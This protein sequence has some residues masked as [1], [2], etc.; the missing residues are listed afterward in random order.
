[1]MSLSPLSLALLLTAS[2]ASA[3]DAVYNVTVYN[4]A[5][6]TLDVAPVALAGS[7][8]SPGSAN[9]PLAAT[10][11]TTDRRQTSQVKYLSSTWCGFVQESPAAGVYDQAVAE[12]TLPS[13]VPDSVVAAVGTST[14]SDATDVVL[15]QFVGVDGFTQS[16]TCSGGLFG[17]TAYSF[18]E[19]GSVA[20]IYAWW[21]FLPAGRNGVS[22]DGESQCFIVPVFLVVVLISRL[23]CWKLH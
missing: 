20:Q 14:G 6:E 22:L 11:T 15:A 3:Q 16:A 13:V 23:T 2:L 21:E 4:A 5:G 18:A 19:D 12:W 9:A 10:T 7:A 1:M 8:V 17:G